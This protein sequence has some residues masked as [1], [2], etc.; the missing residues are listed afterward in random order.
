MK[1]ACLS[2]I[3]V[4]YGTPQIVHLTQ[5]LARYAGD[6]RPLLIENDQPERPAR[7]GQYP[8]I[9]IR[10]VPSPHHPYS[11]LGA[12]RYLNTASEMLDAHRPDILLLPSTY[13]LP[14]L[15]LMKHRPR[16]VIYYVLEMPDAFGFTRDEH[17]LN[18]YSTDRIDLAIYPEPNRAKIHIDT[19]GLHH[20]PGLILFNAP[21]RDD[22]TPLPTT[23]RN[24]RLLYQG[25]IHEELTRGD[26]FLDEVVQGLPIDLY[27]IVDSR[28]D[29]FRD[30]LMKGRRGVR[31]KGY[32]DSVALRACRRHYAFSI[33]YWNPI[34]D[35]QKYA[36]P[37]KFFES[38][39]D[40]VPPITA[41]HP[42]C[43][44]LTEQYQL[45]LVMDDWSQ[46]SFTRA[47]EQAVEM[48]GT[49]RYER[50]VRNCRE[51]FDREL[52]WDTQF[53]KVAR[54]LDRMNE[55]KQGAA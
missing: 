18:R 15:W 10:R 50:M 12:V 49:P 28:D 2:N 35:N 32:L 41:P 42:Q 1:V 25:T 24:G 11:R 20:V 46:E 4:G 8:E 53:E 54:M 37:N 51:A 16:F 29:K 7:H 44:M 3:S 14:A 52:N 6:A 21:P 19:F 47:L 38:I 5:S 23:Q 9:D 33:V 34:N 36:C 48:I 26:F 22:L 27:G 55:R 17:R 30:G 40:G 13:S 45:G 43:R 39:A 31:Y